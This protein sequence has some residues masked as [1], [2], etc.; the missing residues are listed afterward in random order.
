[1]S[2][3]YIYSYKKGS[4]SCKNIQEALKVVNML[5]IRCDH[6]SKPP[7]KTDTV[8]VW[9]NT[10]V[11]NWIPNSYIN[12]PDKIEN[13]CDKLKTFNILRDSGVSIPE[14]T[15]DPIVAKSWL[16]KSF[17]VC[18]TLLKASGGAG[19]ILAKTEED[20][21]EAPLYVKYKRKDKEFRV[22]VFKGEVLHI[23]E[24][25][26]KLSDEKATFNKYIRNH[27]NGWVFCVT[28]IIEPDGIRELALQACKALELDFCA[29]DIIYNSKY[30][31]M[32]VL[33]CNTAPGIEN[34][35]LSQYVKAITNELN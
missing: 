24:K 33:E 28:D 15:T 3:L 35:T 23:Q 12:T 19:I 22:H 5:S 25:R 16:N 26:K 10:K 21:V 18:R 17:V 20:F 13:A 34:T 31:K 29:V 6:T 8:L 27:S 9:G 7:K 11:P 2:R 32:Y 30:N 4:Q 14:Y 1:M